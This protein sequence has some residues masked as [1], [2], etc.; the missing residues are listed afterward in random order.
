MNLNLTHTQQAKIVEIVSAYYNNNELVYQS[1]CD[2]VTIIELKKNNRTT[3]VKTLTRDFYK[4]YSANVIKK[5]IDVALK[6][7]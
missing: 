3:K 2:Y 7:T 5:A 6:I 4:K 1:A